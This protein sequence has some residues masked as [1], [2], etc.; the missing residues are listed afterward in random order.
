MIIQRIVAALL[1]VLFLIAA[2]V[3]VSFLLA[4]ALTAGLLLGG[5]MWW[6]GRG[7]RGRTIEGEYRVVTRVTR[8]ERL[9]QRKRQ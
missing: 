4:L 7:R 6:R 9:P 5:W 8:V 2:F 3:F 1:G